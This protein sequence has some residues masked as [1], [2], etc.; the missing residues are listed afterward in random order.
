MK[1]HIKTVMEAVFDTPVRP[2]SLGKDFYIG[3]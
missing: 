1:N 2:D 3:L